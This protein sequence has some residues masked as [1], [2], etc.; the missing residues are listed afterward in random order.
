[1]L[2][3]SYDGRVIINMDRVIFIRVVVRSNAS[4]LEF[5]Y[6]SG[7]SEEYVNA[8]YDSQEETLTV[9]N[10]IARA[11]ENGKKVFRMPKPGCVTDIVG[12]VPYPSA[13]KWFPDVDL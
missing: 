1:M 7:G 10:S 11:Y 8:V 13:K 2:I 12:Q 5:V 6:I 3:F 4:Y 9:L